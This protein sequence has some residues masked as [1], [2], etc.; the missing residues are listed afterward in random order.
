VNSI[1]KKPSES[2]RC[3]AEMITPDR[4]SMRAIYLGSTLAIAVA[5]VAIG[6]VV[7]LEIG[8]AE[9]NLGVPPTEHWYLKLAWALVRFPLDYFVPWDRLSAFLRD[10][11]DVSDPLG[12]LIVGVIYFINGLLWGAVT[13]LVSRTAVLIWSRWHQNH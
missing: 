12:F 8:G 1:V 9:D 4:K 3:G 10:Q 2:H 11:G 5:W 13:V 7:G 6:V